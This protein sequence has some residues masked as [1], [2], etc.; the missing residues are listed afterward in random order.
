MRKPA[1]NRPGAASDRPDEECPSRS[2]KKRESAALQK[3]GE[4]LAGLTPAEREQTSLP[5]ELANALADLDAIKDREARRRQKQF[6]GRIMRE[7]DAA[8]IAD[9]I[10]ALPQNQALRMALDRQKSR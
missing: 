2:A 1:R 7:V 3:L 4:K 9:A 5:E 8:A 6:I 10:A